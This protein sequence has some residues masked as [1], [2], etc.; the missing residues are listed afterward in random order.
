MNETKPPPL[1]SKPKKPWPMIWIVIAILVYM[2]FQ[3]AWIA[4]GSRN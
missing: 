4:F 3:M 2:L 1:P